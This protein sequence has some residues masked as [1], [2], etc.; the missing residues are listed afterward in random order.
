MG[1]DLLW[2]GVES[3]GFGAEKGRFFVNGYKIGFGLGISIWVWAV[4][5][6]CG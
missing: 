3:V 2:I 1:R 5:R 4:E 6:G